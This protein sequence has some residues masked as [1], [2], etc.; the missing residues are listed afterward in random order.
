[1]LAYEALNDWSDALLWTYPDLAG[2]LRQVGLET[3]IRFQIRTKSN[4]PRIEFQ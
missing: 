1:M 3:E 2:D 4:M